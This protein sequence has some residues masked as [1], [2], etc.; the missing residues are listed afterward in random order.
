MNSIKQKKGFETRSYTI[1]S[2]SEFVEV[3]YKSIKDKLKYKIHLTEVGNQIQFEA[4]NV[5]VGKIFVSLTTLITLVCIGIYF[6]GHPDKPGTYVVNSIIWG[7]LSL[8]GF[9]R[10]HKDDI[11]IT[12]G[13]KLIRLFRTKPNEEKVKE[14]AHNLIEIANSKKKEMLINFDLNEAQFMA[15]IQWLLNMK[16]IDKTELEELKS[17][18]QLKKLI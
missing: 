12:N 2:E 15:N 5:I 3:E 9:L 7:T 16:I 13:N 14:F 1:D 4:D 11:L 8:F 18:F 17:E 10:P 6:F